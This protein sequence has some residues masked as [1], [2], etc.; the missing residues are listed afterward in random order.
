MN[1]KSI[2]LKKMATWTIAVFA[3]VFAVFMALFWM[4]VYPGTSGSV[5]NALSEAL[6]AGWLVFLIAAVLSLVTYFGYKLYLDRKK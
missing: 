1:D 2:K 4:L 5:W 3:T 6:S